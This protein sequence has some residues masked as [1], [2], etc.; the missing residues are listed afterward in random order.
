MNDAHVESLQLLATPF[1][2]ETHQPFAFSPG[3]MW[4]GITA[5]IRERIPVM[6]DHRLTPPPRETY[7]LNRCVVPN[8]FHERANPRTNRK[9]S[10]AFLLASRLRATVDC[11]KL[12]DSVV[13]DYTFSTN[14]SLKT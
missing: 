2:K 8:W 12:W 1:R 7:S 9:L 13:G 14:P 4:A 11:R 6:L 10:G 5:D 3:S